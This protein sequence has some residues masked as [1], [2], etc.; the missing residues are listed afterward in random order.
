LPALYNG[1]PLNE[2]ISIPIT[3]SPIPSIVLSHGILQDTS[4]VLTDGT[5]L[6]ISQET[7]QTLS[8]GILLDTSLENRLPVG[9][10]QGN[11]S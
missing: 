3:N 4:Q 5:L 1:I 9:T 8:D 10:I 7:R 2:Q 11:S 6:D